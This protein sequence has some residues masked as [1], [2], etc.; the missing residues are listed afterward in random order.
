M[1]ELNIPKKFHL[2][3]PRRKK[4]PTWPGLSVVQFGGDDQMALARAAAERAAGMAA[5]PNGCNKGVNVLG[6]IP[7]SVDRDFA[8]FG[9]KSF[10]INKINTVD[11]RARHPHG[12]GAVYGWGLTALFFLLLFAGGNK[13]PNATPLTVFGLVL[14]ALFGFLAYKAW[15]RSQ[16]I[17]YQLFLVTSSG[18]VQAI[19]SEDPSMIDELR[20]RIERAM[21]GRVD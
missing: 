20:D 3:L 9:S 5:W 7:V 15:K 19:K 4:A 16:I 1:L 14:C 8:R 21:A 18:A 17:E 10:A 6:E 13:G 2:C 11:V 12:Q